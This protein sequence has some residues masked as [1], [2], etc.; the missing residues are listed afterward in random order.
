MA[1]WDER[2]RET[3]AEIEP[4][5]RAISDGHYEHVR[6]IDVLLRDAVH[7]R[8]AY[9]FDRWRELL[10]IVRRQV[11]ANDRQGPRLRA[12]LPDGAMRFAYCA[13][14]L[15]VDLDPGQHVAER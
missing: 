10:E 4:Q 2:N 6:R 3:A 1:G 8:R 14:R 12:V 11:A 13:L 7:I 15:L 9:R 5:L